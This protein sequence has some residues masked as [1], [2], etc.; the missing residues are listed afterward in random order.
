MKLGMTLE[1]SVFEKIG[2]LG[3]VIPTHRENNFPV[4][5]GLSRGADAFN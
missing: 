2:V 5:V 4:F 3:P 1:K